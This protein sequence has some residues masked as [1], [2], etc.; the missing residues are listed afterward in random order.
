MNFQWDSIKRQAIMFLVALLVIG[1]YWY[2]DPNGG[3]E[4]LMRLQHMAWV[5]VAIYVVYTCRRWLIP[6][7]M[8]DAYEEA[9]QTSQGAGLVFIGQCIAV[10]ALLL[11][12]GGR[13]T[14]QDIPPNA[15]Y[16]LPIL[17]QTIDEHWP[18]MPM[19]SVIAAQIE[20]ETCISLAHSR[21]WSRLAEL[22]TS[23]ENGIGLFQV[24]V[25]YRADGSELFNTFKDVQKLDASLAGWEWGDRYDARR[26]MIS[27]V[28]LN[29]KCYD[30]MVKLVPDPYNALAM[31][32]AAHN[33]GMGG[34]LSERRMCLQVK[35]CDPAKWFG[36]VE[37]HSLKNRQRWQGYGQSAFEINRGHVKA[38]MIT[39]RPKYAA[40]FQET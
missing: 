4:T 20:Q 29:K 22:K 14:A 11:L 15:K 8:H 28:L 16:Y 2:N 1:L 36:H 33:G 25:A 7:R 40:W 17:S 32:D 24:T 6:G 35:G 26:Q 30:A 34:L 39:R 13:A 31:C 10:A 21:C 18:A 9:M 19:R 27:G 12:I 38:V 37:N 23:R 3:R 5:L